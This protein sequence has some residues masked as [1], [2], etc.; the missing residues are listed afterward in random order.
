MKLI[1]AL[2]GIAGVYAAACT[3]MPWTSCVL[4]GGNGWH[5]GWVRRSKIFDCWWCDSCGQRLRLGRRAYN[6]SVRLRR[7][8]QAR[9]TERAGK[10]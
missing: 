7:E 8:G 9:R 2:L 3:W 10:R 5:R 4:C 6:H 1:F